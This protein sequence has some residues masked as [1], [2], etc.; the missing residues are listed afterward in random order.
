MT[1]DEIMDALS[2]L[3]AYDVGC[4]DS[5]IHHPEL[6]ERVKAQLLAMPPTER[7]VILAGIGRDLYLTDAMIE[8]GYGLEDIRGFASW[9]E[10]DLGVY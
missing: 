1:R 4:T 8:K 3:H 2:G 10:G 9:V 7:R 5:G 6:R